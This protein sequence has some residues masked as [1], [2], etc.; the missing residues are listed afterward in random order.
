MWRRG[1]EESGG[2]QGPFL[3]VSGVRCLNHGTQLSI[4]G[5]FPYPGHQA[6]DC[7]NRDIPSTLP[8]IVSSSSAHNCSHPVLAPL[9][10]VLRL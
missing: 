5:H 1:G 3:C 7:L 4:L 2:V 6:T 8:N 10:I 9:H